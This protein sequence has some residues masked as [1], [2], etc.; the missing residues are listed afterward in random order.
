MNPIELIVG[1]SF[2]GLSLGYGSYCAFQATL[3]AIFP[4]NKLRFRERYRAQK[5]KTISNYKQNN[6][7]EY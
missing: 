6:W 2:I 4:K 5:A 3:S 1:S 7:I